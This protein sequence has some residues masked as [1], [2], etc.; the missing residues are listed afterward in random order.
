MLRW[1]NRSHLIV[2]RDNNYLSALIA[3][4]SCEIVSSH[5][6][7]STLSFVCALLYRC[8][9]TACS[10]V[11]WMLQRSCWQWPLSIVCLLD[12]PFVPRS[13][14]QIQI[15]ASIYFDERIYQKKKSIAAREPPSLPAPCHFDHTHVQITSN[16]FE[17]G[18][19]QVQPTVRTRRTS[20]NDFNLDW[21]TWTIHLSSAIAQGIKV[22]ISVRRAW[23]ELR[24]IQCSNEFSIIVLRSTCCGS[25]SNIVISGST[26]ERTASRFISSRPAIAWF[27]SSSTILGRR[28]A[29]IILWA[30]HTRR[31]IASCLVTDDL[32][33]K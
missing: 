15:N 10:R 13:A 18:W 33:R 27:A 25:T 5:L 30:T 29:V 22:G 21:T 8:Q 9:I 4:S 23:V 28:T 20:I 2:Q 1:T 11:Q 7:N 24:S 19:R 17:G 12:L 32:T 16:C 6:L 31:A 3:S 26:T 14:D